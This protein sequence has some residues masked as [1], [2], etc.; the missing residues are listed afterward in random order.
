MVGIHPGSGVMRVRCP[1]WIY[2][3]DVAPDVQQV[4][5]NIA[6]HV[7]KTGMERNGPELL[8]I[9][10]AFKCNFRFNGEGRDFGH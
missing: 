3:N 2:T 7:L 9:K 10:T 6:E 8:P 4:S 1:S 5:K